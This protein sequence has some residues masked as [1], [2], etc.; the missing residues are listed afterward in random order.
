[1]S[2]IKYPETFEQCFNKFMNHVEKLNISPKTKYGYSQGVR[3]CTQLLLGK[4]MKILPYSVGDKEITFLKD[5]AFENLEIRTKRWYLC[6][7]NKFMLFFDNLTMQKMG[8]SWPHDR[9]VHVDWLT[10]DDAR[11]LVNYPM[12]LDQQMAIHLELCMGLRRVEVIRL[13]VSNI[14]QD[15]IDVRGKGRYG[16]KW[17]SIPYSKD[18]PYIIERYNKKRNALIREVK[19]INPAVIV[20]GELFIYRKGKELY[21]YGE[22]GSGFDA[23]YIHTVRDEIGF[24]FSNHTLRRTFGRTLWKNKVEIEKIAEIMG[25][26]S[27]DVTM[28]Y[29]GVNMDDMSDAMNQLE[30]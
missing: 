9:R 5:V 23:A 1:M 3:K 18:I 16:G 12:N 15:H 21:S 14:Y 6:M 28:K 29:I 17:R 2:N 20:P 22:K 4:R 10:A 25:H 26:E 30:F 8:L 11:K 19:L 27:I 24:H 13:K 7:Y